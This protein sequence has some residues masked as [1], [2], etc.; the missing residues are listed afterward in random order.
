M[1]QGFVTLNL[2]TRTAKN[3]KLNLEKIDGVKSVLATDDFNYTIEM[4][5]RAELTDDIA[6]EALKSGAGLVEL[7]RSKNQLEDVFLRL[8]YGQNASAQVSNEVS[9]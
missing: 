3:I 7:V 5:D 6:A 1:N 8:T 4:S 2:K 9:L